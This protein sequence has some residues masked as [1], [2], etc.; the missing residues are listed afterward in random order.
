MSID[1]RKFIL[2][3]GLGIAAAA[4]PISLLGKNDA[5]AQIKRS[6]RLKLKFFPY[7]LKL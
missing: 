5:P 7:E 6:G 1:R 2:G 4:S 3:A